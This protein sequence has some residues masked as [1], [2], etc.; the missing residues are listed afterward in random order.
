M[1]GASATSRR[2]RVLLLVSALLHLLPG[3]SYLLLSLFVLT[4]GQFQLLAGTGSLAAG[5]CT[6]YAVRVASLRTALSVLLVGLALVSPALYLGG[7]AV[8]R[9]FPQDSI[10]P[11]LIPLMGLMLH[12]AAVAPLVTLGL[13]YAERRLPATE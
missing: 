2:P 12:L 1:A 10:G 9:A 7:E 11:G 6:L 13:I 4:P 5:L 8:V 3:L